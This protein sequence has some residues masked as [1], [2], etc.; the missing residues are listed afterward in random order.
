MLL[1]LNLK[2]KRPNGEELQGNDDMAQSLSDLLASQKTSHIKLLKAW[3][4]AQKLSADKCVDIDKSDAMA[5][6]KFIEECSLS[7][8]ASAQL[9]EQLHN[10]KE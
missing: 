6:E 3:G 5:L 4:W 10:L 2:F 1:D 8:F 7:P 9:L